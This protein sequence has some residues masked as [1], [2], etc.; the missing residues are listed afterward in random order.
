MLLVLLGWVD[1]QLKPN[2]L[3][4]YFH[5]SPPLW[6]TVKYF[7]KPIPPTSLIFFMQLKVSTNLFEYLNIYL[8]VWPQFIFSLAQNP[9][10]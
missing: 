7:V 3:P 2:K 6:S 10:L 4:G 9:F 1:A 8:M 5:Y